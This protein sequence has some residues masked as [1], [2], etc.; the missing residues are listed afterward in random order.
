[1]LEQISFADFHF[2]RPYWLLA[3]PLIYLIYVRLKSKI[4]SAAQWQSF[5]ASHLLKHLT[6]KGSNKKRMRPYQLFTLLL[7]LIVFILS[8]PTFQPE[9]T[10]FTE[11]RA[12]LV[13]ALELTYTMLA[14]D[15]APTRL[16]RA[17]QKI[18]DL[19]K[20]RQGARTGLIAYAGS[21]HI[22]LPLTDD[23]ELMEIFL[24]SLSPSIMPSEGSQAS[25]ALKLSASILQNE[26]VPGTVLFMTDGVDVDFSTKAE[27]FT[28][29]SEDQILFLAF[30]TEEGAPIKD[31]SGV[32]L[33]NRIAP[34]VDLIGLRKTAK[35][36]NASLIQASIDEEDINSLVNRINTH[37]V[38]ALSQDENVQWKDTGYYLCWLLALL[39]L[40]W[41][42]KGW[43]IQ[44]A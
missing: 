34:G 35:A 17:K 11:D 18:R 6:I 41:F 44:W 32:N 5:V 8:G 42:R 36:N 21:A 24:E 13:I 14:Q 10:P 31:A 28:A 30:G 23:V 9:V 33:E 29:N 43:T 19:L 16:E 15:L 27:E 20:R 2:I 4:R 40:F 37:L 39:S 38:N 22:V 12:P 25:Q 26:E 7:G 3:L 1:M